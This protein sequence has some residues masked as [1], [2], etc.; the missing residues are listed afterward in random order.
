MIHIIQ[1]RLPDEYFWDFRKFKAEVRARDN[2]EAFMKLMEL[3]RNRESGNDNV[4]QEDLLFD[5]EGL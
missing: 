5:S 3:A 4:C 1:F 2:A